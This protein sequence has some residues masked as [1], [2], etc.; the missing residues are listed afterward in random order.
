MKTGRKKELSM[1]V[2]QELVV[3]A[4]N[5]AGGPYRLSKILK[6]SHPHLS[7]ARTGE[8][9]ISL[10]LARFVKRYLFGSRDSINEAGQG[11]K[12]EGRSTKAGDNNL[13]TLS[14]PLT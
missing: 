10:K 2:S 8:N 14:R 5:K 9:G 6:V 4:C 1:E 11:R 7:R 12:V 13:T 3:A